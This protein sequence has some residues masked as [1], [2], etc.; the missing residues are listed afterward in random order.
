M[1]QIIKGDIPSFW[2]TYVRKHPN[3]FYLEKGDIEEKKDVIKRLRKYMLE[4]QKGICCYCCASLE[5]ENAHNEHIRPRDSYPDLSMDY[6]N[7]LAS[8]RNRNTCGMKKGSQFEEKK[9]VSPLEHGCE[10]EFIFEPD[11]TIV[12]KTIR[13]I[14]T[15]NLLNLNTYA[16]KAARQALYKQ[17]CDM[18]QNGK[19][20]VKE[21]YIDARDGKLP[22]FVDMVEYFYNRGDFDYC[23]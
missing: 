11:G 20:C 8:C 7:M 12:G 9:F 23:N 17:C 22:R 4:E 21:Y 1:K 5:Y 10:D 6:N 16:L 19:E 13:G 2:K 3:E 15:V 18:A 14:Y